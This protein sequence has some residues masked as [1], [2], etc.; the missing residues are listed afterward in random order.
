MSIGQ[1][2]MKIGELYIERCIPGIPSWKN[3]LKNAKAA[4]CIQIL[5]VTC[6]CSGQIS[7]KICEL[8]I[9]RHIKCTLGK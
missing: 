3:D 1:I 9:E 8:Y 2:L 6:M 4:F 5:F 7:M